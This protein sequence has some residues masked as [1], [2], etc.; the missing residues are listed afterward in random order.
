MGKSTRFPSLRPK[1]MLTHPSG[2]F[3]GVEALRGINLDAFS[4]VYFVTHK[5]YQDEY[6]F[7]DGFIK[8]LKSINKNINIEFVLLEQQTA[9]QPET[10]YECIKIKN[11]SGP[12]LVKDSDNYFEATIADEGNLV[13]YFDLND[14]DQFN[15]RNKSYVQFDTNGFLDNIVE[16]KIISSTFSVG[17]YGFASAE[18]FCL[19]FK[20]LA[21]LTSEVYMSNIIFQMILSGHKF[22]GIKTFNYEDWGTLEEWNRYK[23]TF[24]TLFVDLD[25]VLIENASVHMHP[26]IGTGKPLHNNIKLLQTLYKTGR[27]KIIITTA[28]PTEYEEQTKLELQSHNIP[29]DI[30]I[31]GLPHSQRILINDFA[32]SNPYPSSTAINLE[33]N[34]NNLG[35]YLL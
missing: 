8:E 5:D 10:V 12:I 21:H 25:G 3:M 17:G 24:R 7:I 1:W 2:M 34:M 20:Q 22:S 19:Y 6:Q 27:T 29:Y 13:C 28:R 15:A 14:G 31:M 23:K 35:T 11:I 33:R 18:E 26:F 16:K 30:L 9:S 32:K 4:T